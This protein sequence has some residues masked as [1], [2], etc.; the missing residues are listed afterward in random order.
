MSGAARLADARRNIAAMPE[1]MAAGLEYF[2]GDG[3]ENAPPKA[4]SRAAQVGDAGLKGRG[5][6][7][8]RD[9]PAGERVTAYPMDTVCNIRARAGSEI[10]V[11]TLALAPGYADLEY[12]YAAYGQPVEGF[13]LFTHIVGDPARVE[14]PETL[15]HIANS[16][17]GDPFTKC[18]ASPA[19]YF[20]AT[21][22]Y[23]IV[24]MSRSNSVLVL[25]HPVYLVAFRPILEGE[26]LLVTYGP[27]YWPLPDRAPAA[28]RGGDLLEKAIAWAEKHD[29]ALRE[30]IRTVGIKEQ[31]LTAAAMSRSA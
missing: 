21:L 4:A 14:L 1:F 15:A 18:D 20:R 26:E 23:M 9:I 29:P 24:S 13:E 11:P 3:W 27:G 17:S 25:G 6:F 5:L 19:S 28:V 7:A 16:G 12:M 30:R 8:T 31:A 10:K 22:L 2:M